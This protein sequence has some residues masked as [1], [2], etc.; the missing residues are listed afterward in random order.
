MFA[1]SGLEFL[2][3]H[4]DYT[5]SSG[6]NQAVIDWADGLMKAHPRRRAIVT[7]HW[8][9]D[10]PPTSPI[11]TPAPFG[12]PGQR[13]FDE[14]KDNPNFFLM[15]SGHQHGEGRRADVFQ[16]RTVHSVLQDY[17]ARANGGNGWLRYFV[18]SPANNTITAKTYSP[19]LPQSETDTDATSS[20]RNQA[21]E[22][23]LPYNMQTAV[24][25]WTVL[26]TV[27]VAAGGGP[28]QFNWTGLDEGSTYE[29]YVSAS[30]SQSTT[31]SPARIFSTADN[32]A[33]TVT[34]TSPTNNAL[35]TT[36]VD[37][38]LT[39]TAGDVAG[40]V[41]KVEFFADATKLGEDTTSP[42]SFTWNSALPGTYALTA[43][44]TD[45]DTAPTTS[46]PIA[47]TVNGQ[48]NLLPTVTLTSPAN[49]A[50]VTALSDVTLTAAAGDSDGTV[51]KVEFFQGVT[52]LG[53]DTTSPYSF[54]WNSVPA[55]SYSLTA[56]ATD[57]SNATA[58]SIAANIIANIPPSVALTAPANGATFTTPGTMTLTATA[59]DVD[60]TVTLVEFY[61]GAT[62]VGEDATSPYSYTWTNPPAGGPALTARATD[63]RG[64]TT[65]SSPATIQI[66]GTPPA[67][68]VAAYD[69]DD[70]A[71]A[72]LTDITGRGRNGTISGATWTTS[73]H[74][75]S[76]LTFGGSAR[77]T[78]PDANE[79][80]LTA[81][82]T[83]EAWVYP[84]AVP[85][86]WSTVI[87]KENSPSLAYALYAG[88]PANRPEGYVNNGA[89]RGTTGTAAL[90]QN[91]WTHLATTYDGATL[92][93]YVNGTQVASQAVT[94][95]IR[96]SSGVLSIGGN[97][98]WGEYFS[99]RLDEVRIYN[100]A[101]SA[102]EVQTDMN[103]PVR[104]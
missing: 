90:P 34:L 29:W 14:F 79:L 96:T 95:A 93:L 39:A 99:G 68:P 9:L 35:F 61:S 22:F 40:T 49:N 46:P 71:G 84:T 42:Y 78:V 27:N 54:T 26:G 104:R 12:G 62:K 31:T 10:L 15:L 43:R 20:P 52:K 28:A 83:L 1:A 69:F 60:G 51:S 65:I 18:F 81:A 32:V 103:T 58:T 3:I 66:T 13:F 91:T 21:S 2:I 53:E 100:R 92:R 67:G 94:G 85:T 37:I 47:I 73:G 76:A 64:A 101:L 41:A 88:T 59:S 89:D 24:A 4:L 56:R 80:D 87:L 75:G 30:D 86:D 6:V 11:P 70:G 44:A 74:S 98:V 23:V 36:P 102:A 17:Q 77:V 45:D 38:T 63:N 7:S 48:S 25:P 97:G 57:S 19:T 82:M 5:T 33:P 8:I 50:I 55:G 16:G 72:V